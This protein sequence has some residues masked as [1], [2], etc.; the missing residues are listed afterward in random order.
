[1]FKELDKEWLSQDLLTRLKAKK[2][3]HRQR[4]QA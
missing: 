1:M 2:E 3:M 4:D